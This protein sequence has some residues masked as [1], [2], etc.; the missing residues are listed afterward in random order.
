MKK[1]AESE[2]IPNTLVTLGKKL[3]IMRANKKGQ[4]ET[5]LY[6]NPSL[7][8]SPSNFINNLLMGTLKVANPKIEA[9]KK[10]NN[11]NLRTTSPND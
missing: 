5:I 3:A 10:L 11:K 4:T 7:Y 6:L 2:T 8:S 9:V 1:I